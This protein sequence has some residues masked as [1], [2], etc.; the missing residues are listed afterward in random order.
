MSLL[1]KTVHVL[2]GNRYFGDDE[3][4]SSGTKEM[5]DDQYMAHF[6]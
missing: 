5:D 4:C 1:K 6:D 2:A 3:F